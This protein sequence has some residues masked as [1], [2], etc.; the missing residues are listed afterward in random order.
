[1]L[2]WRPTTSNLDT[3]VEAKLSE[4]LPQLYRN[5]FLLATLD[6]SVLKNDS[7]TEYQPFN[8][9][10]AGEHEPFEQCVRKVV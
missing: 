9:W 5:P 10:G 4:E 6:P 7:S 2:F 1:M 8:S 3:T